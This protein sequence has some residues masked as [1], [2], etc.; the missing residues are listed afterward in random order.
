MVVDEGHGL[1]RPPANQAR[2]LA[3]AILE[4]PVLALA[5]SILQDAFHWEVKGTGSARKLEADVMHK[6]GDL[7][8]CV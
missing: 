3:I 8:T 1:A 5:G 4:P 7:F 2:H 6:C